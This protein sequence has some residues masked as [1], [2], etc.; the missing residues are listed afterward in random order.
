MAAMPRKSILIIAGCALLLL[1]VAGVSRL[2]SV[3]IQVDGQTLQI[4][5]L[6]LNVGWALHDARVTLSPA[7]QVTP[8]LTSSIG[9]QVN[10]EVIRARQVNLYTTAAAPD[11]TFYSASRIPAGLLE[12]AGLSLQPGERLLWNGQAIDPQQPLPDAAQ[13][14]LQLITAHSITVICN[15]VNRDV[16]T[17]GASLGAGLWAAGQMVSPAD[18]LSAPYDTAL[19]S[20]SSIVLK[21][22]TPITV[23]VDGGTV[24]GKSAAATVGQALT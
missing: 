23:Q 4:H 16:T 13:Y 3:T 17:T 22:A 12:E 7:D 1:A 10:V 19:D 18:F 11:K 6:A 24:S 20:Q 14:N 5:S 21:T 15:A 8:P 2:R 9:W